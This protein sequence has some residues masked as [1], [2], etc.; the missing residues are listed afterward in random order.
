MQRFD[1]TFIQKIDY[2]TLNFALK[3]LHKNKCEW[4]LVLDRLDISLHNDLK[5]AVFI[6]IKR[7]VQL[8]LPIEIARFEKN[9][10]DRHSAMV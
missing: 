10:Y 1:K 9:R 8:S 2:V 6:T 7:S 4:L 5:I 3:H